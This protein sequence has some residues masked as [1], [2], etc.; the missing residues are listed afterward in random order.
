MMYHVHITEQAFEDMGKIYRY[1]FDTLQAPNAAKKQYNRIAKAIESLNLFPKRIKPIDI[2]AAGS[3]VL[4]QMLVDHY[5]IIFTIDEDRIIVLSVLYS[6]SD[7][8]K[9]LETLLPTEQ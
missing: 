3:Q 6:A 5:S 2:D 7:T 9:R 1:I 8:R 4:R